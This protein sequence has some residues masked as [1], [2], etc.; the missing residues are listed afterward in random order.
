MAIYSW[1]YANAKM[2]GNRKDY[3]VRV[4]DQGLEEYKRT[5]ILLSNRLLSTDRRFDKAEKQSCWFSGYIGDEKKVYL[6]AVGGEQET[7]LGVSLA[8]GG[9]RTQHCVL[10]YGFTENDIQLYR[11]EDS[12]FEPLKEILRQIQQAGRDLESEPEQMQGQ[13]FDVY[14]LHETPPEPE[15]SYNIIQSTPTVDTTLWGQ[16]LK[17]PI[18]TGIIS[19]DDAKKL[20][21][22]FPDGLVSVMENVNLQYAVVRKTEEEKATGKLSSE[23]VRSEDFDEEEKKSLQEF[24][25]LPSSNPHMNRND[26][27]SSEKGENVDSSNY[28]G[29]KLIT[30]M[31][32]F[33]KG[34]MNKVQQLEKQVK[35][36]ALAEK[37]GEDLAFVQ[38]YANFCEI[39]LFS[40]Q[41]ESIKKAVRKLNLP[42]KFSKQ[43]EYYG[44]MR[45]WLYNEEK[46]E[47]ITDEYEIYLI[48]REW[49]KLQKTEKN[50][51]R[52]NVQYAK[53]IERKD[54]KNGSI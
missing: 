23:I 2:E 42:K 7:I 45:L 9:F 35:K 24:G 34:G 21:Q 15:K 44:Y 41:K 13:Y 52:R 53:D 54:K 4:C 33:A 48:I 14:V 36:Q 40:E 29:T 17:R 25:I 32:T 18:M 22:L 28:G 5:L 6:V 38:E 8:G 47:P 1:I 26:E 50:V 46:V 31:V 30:N 43:M 11:Q 16:S 3:H 51:F 12:M 39:R 49:A 19:T 37:R 27:S 10:G 20:L